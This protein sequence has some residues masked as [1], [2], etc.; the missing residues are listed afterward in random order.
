MERKS[1]ERKRRRKIE[2]ASKDGLM[3]PFTDSTER[4]MEFI[5]CGWLVDAGSSCCFI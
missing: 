1:Q 4:A 2:R 3:H 5:T